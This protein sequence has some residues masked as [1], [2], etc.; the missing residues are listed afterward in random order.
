M[1]HRWP[2]SVERLFWDVDPADV[3]LRVH[4]DYVMERVMTRGTLEAMRWLRAT[5]SVAELAAFLERCGERLAPRD[6]AYW[7]LVADLPRE[8]EPSGARPPWNQ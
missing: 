1:S 8:R 2:A 6:R 5:Y 4:A 3:E 7:R